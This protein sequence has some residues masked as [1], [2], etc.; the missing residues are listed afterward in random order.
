[1]TLAL[2]L[3]T[4]AVIP[5]T[6]AVLGRGSELKLSVSHTSGPCCL[7]MLQM[8]EKTENASL[9]SYN[10]PGA[11]DKLQFMY[12]VTADGIENGKMWKKTIVISCVCIFQFRPTLRGFP[13]IPIPFALDSNS[14]Y[15]N[16]SSPV[17]LVFGGASFNVSFEKGL[18][19]I[20]VEFYDYDKISDAYETITNTVVKTGNGTIILERTCEVRNKTRI[21]TTILHEIF[22][23]SLRRD[24]QIAFC[25]ND[26]SGPLFRER[27]TRSNTITA[28]RPPINAVPL[29]RQG[30]KTISYTNVTTS[31]VRGGIKT[32]N[33]SNSN[34][35]FF[36]RGIK[37]I[38]SSNVTVPFVR[39]GIQIINST[40]VTVSSVRG[41]NRTINST[42][43]STLSV[44]KG[45]KTINSTNATASYVPG[46][47]KTINSTNATAS[48]V[49]GGIKTINSTNATA[50]SVPG[51][52][53]T[54]NSTNATASSVP[55]GIKTNNH[56]NTTE[57]Q[58]R[59]NASNDRGVP[60]GRPN[61][62]FGKLHDETFI[63]Y[64]R[65]PSA[66]S[67]S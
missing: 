64:S 67:V 26:C 31:S 24:N 66:G 32:I 15:F 65:R 14:T 58:A 42:N 48:S 3:V 61:S 8:L 37:T 19:K 50:S 63:I 59:S 34:V 25:V 36:R 13:N 35:P 29:V 57:S 20:F 51:G 12:G 55:G 1:M 18:R 6:S 10:N 52:I 30:T 53:K 44:P 16:G 4:F 5:M 60:Q 27:I 22:L 17:T 7:K 54:I 43:A 11:A 39:G 23:A 62:E 2:L 49:P 21:A 9:L 45:I 33:S 38:N 41:G 47:I 28:L 40:N 56:S 46:G